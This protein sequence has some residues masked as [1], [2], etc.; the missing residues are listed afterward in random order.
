[1]ETFVKSSAGYCVVTYLM[2]V[3]D[4]HLD[5]VCRKFLCDCSTQSL[6]SSSEMHF[7]QN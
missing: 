5:N 3:G 4:R 6:H 7:G 2:G 1:M